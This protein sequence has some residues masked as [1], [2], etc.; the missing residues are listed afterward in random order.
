MW[1]KIK[2]V[3]DHNPYIC[4]PSQGTDICIDEMGVVMFGEHWKWAKIK[5]TPMFDDIYGES[6]LNPVTVEISSS[7]IEHLHLPV[8]LI[9]QLKWAGRYVI[10]GPVIG[11][12]LGNHPHLYRPGHMKKYSDRL[13]IYEQIGGLIFAFSVQS[14]HWDKKCIAGLF[15][16]PITKGWE[17]GIFPFPFVIYRRNFHVAPGIIKKLMQVTQGRL[18]NSHRFTKYELYKI[19]IKEA[20]LKQHLPATECITSWEDVNNFINLYEKAILKP[21]DLSRGRGIC[22]IKKTPE[23][24]IIDDY[25][26]ATP[27]V[28]KLKSEAELQNFFLS[29]PSLLQNYL[30]QEY[31]DLAKV[32]GSN[33]DIRVVMQKRIGL[34][35]E[36]TGIECRVANPLLLLTNISRGGYALSLPEAFALSFPAEKNFDHYRNIIDTV[37]QKICASL[38]QT[39]EHY[40]ELG[41]DLA[42]D[43]SKNVWIIEANVFPSFKGFITMDYQ[44]YLAIRYKPLLYALSMTGFIGDNPL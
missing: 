9:Y 30:I 29:N 4:L 1:I 11:L 20:G 27:T 6:Y 38:D 7:L 14:I 24:F 25:R 34:K 40:G 44:T 5:T 16:N 23:E 28:L 37:A 31:I 32:N 42:L 43:S 12:L 17:Y 2:A 39:G 41:L 21:L 33:Y 22:I 13:G 36:C 19:L 15:Y 35:W 3:P 18:F 10:L 26:K 8:E